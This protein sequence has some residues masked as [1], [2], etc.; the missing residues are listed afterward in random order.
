[1]GGAWN[2]A[3]IVTRPR[4]SGDGFSFLD[5]TMAEMAEV[6]EL[7]TAQYIRDMQ[8][9]RPAPGAA[10]LIARLR[11][12]QELTVCEGKELTWG[13][14]RAPNLRRVSV[15]SG[16]LGNDA[17]LPV[18]RRGLLARPERGKEASLDSPSKRKSLAEVRPSSKPSESPRGKN[19]ASRHSA[20]SW[21]LTQERLPAAGHL[22]SLSGRCCG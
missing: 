15:Q 11:G 9:V 2:S 1:M 4:H 22:P 10:D 13:F 3:D 20:H 16:T 12:L 19:A 17:G 14:L 21:L 7:E 5:P 18:Y 6:V 8:L